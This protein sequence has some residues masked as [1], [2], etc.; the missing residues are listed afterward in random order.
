MIGYNTVVR[1]RVS[2]APNLRL[3]FPV[4][5]SMASPTPCK[6]SFQSVDFILEILVDRLLGQDHTISVVGFFRQSA[7]YFHT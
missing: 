3:R 6:R 5:S 7:Q 4:S 1:R 2:F